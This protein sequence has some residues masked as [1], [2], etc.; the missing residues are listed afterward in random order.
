MAG[1]IDVRVSF[2]VLRGLRESDLIDVAEA[3]IESGLLNAID[4]IV[5]RWYSF[6]NVRSGE[7]GARSNW[8][9]AKLGVMSYAIQ[10]LA[11]TKA[12][13][14]YAGFVHRA[15]QTSTLEDTLVRR[16]LAK[17]RRE[18]TSNLLGLR[19]TGEAPEGAIRPTALSMADVV[20]DLLLRAFS[21][22]IPSA[23][24]AK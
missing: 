10:N 15:G 9:L 11:R 19:A 24:A 23:L 18:I 1:F 4:R 21:E 7:S 13:K 16:E 17:A 22:S 8:N 14:L 20:L 2:P 12:G 5:A 6:V 3:I